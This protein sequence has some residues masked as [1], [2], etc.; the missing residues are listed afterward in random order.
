MRLDRDVD[1]CLV[2]RL[3]SGC[4]DVDATEEGRCSTDAIVAVGAVGG[5]ASCFFSFA[6]RLRGSKLSFLR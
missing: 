5:R 4:L 6:L 2:C 3:W 1:E